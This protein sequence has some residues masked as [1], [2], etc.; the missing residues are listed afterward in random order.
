M[1]KLISL[2]L[3][4][5]MLALPALSVAEGGLG[6]IGGADGPTAMFVTGATL[7][8]MPAVLGFVSLL[9]AIIGIRKTRRLS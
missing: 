1:K 4:L 9:V 5:L 3:A 7:R 8:V 6:V 2:M